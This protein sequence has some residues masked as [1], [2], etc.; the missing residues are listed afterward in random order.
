M[1]NTK[2]RHLEILQSATEAIRIGGGVAE[3]D[4]LEP[5]KREN[6]LRTMA[7]VVVR[8]TNCHPDTAKRNVAK[9]MRKGRWALMQKK[10]PPDNWGGDRSA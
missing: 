5:E 3:I 7:R 4:K 1:I 8:E 10:A 9:A 6:H 2:A